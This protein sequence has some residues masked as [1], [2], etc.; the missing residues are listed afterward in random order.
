MFLSAAF[1]NGPFFFLGRL[2][3]T[4]VVGS[5]SRPAEILFNFDVILFTYYSSIVIAVSLEEP[6]FFI[7]PA[8]VVDET[9]EDESM[10][11][12]QQLDFA[13]KRKKSIQ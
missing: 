12:K 9:I 11:G 8:I 1:H 10:K 6:L 3:A 13:M 7:F 4:V 5:L 2:V